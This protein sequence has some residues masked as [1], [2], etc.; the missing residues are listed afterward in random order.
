MSNRY[1]MKTGE[2]GQYDETYTF[3]PANKLWTWTTTESSTGSKEQGIADPWIGS[4]WTF[5]GARTMKS[6]SRQKIQMIYTRVSPNE[7]RRDFIVAQRAAPATT[8]SSVCK[9]M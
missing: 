4:T 1:T 7:F 6:G 9:R 5:E 2:T 8:S 3:D